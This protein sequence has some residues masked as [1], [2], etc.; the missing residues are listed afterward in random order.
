MA[1]E[2]SDSDPFDLTDAEICLLLDPFDDPEL[3]NILEARST[4][5]QF[6]NVASNLMQLCGGE[7][8]NGFTVYV[9][10]SSQNYTVC[11]KDNTTETNGPGDIIDA[12]CNGGPVFGDTVKIMI[13]NSSYL[14]LC[15]VQI[16]EFGFQQIYVLF[17][18][19][20]RQNYIT[21]NNL[22]GRLL[23]TPPEVHGIKNIGKYQMILSENN[24]DTHE[25][26]CFAEC[27]NNT[28]GEDCQ[29]TCGHCYNKTE[30][31]TVT[32]E[33]P[34]ATGNIQCDSGYTGSYCV[35]GEY[36]VM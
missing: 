25:M 16:F 1:A 30:C 35:K 28:W 22:Y 14:T 34:V 12:V 31:N 5:H 4:S 20:E 8:L 21:L 32:G 19:S 23:R 24:A 18:I 15:E 9:G 27:K 29:E 7:R 10:N 6:P 36:V 11:Y 33:C 3:E 26:M 2:Q 17:C 13:T